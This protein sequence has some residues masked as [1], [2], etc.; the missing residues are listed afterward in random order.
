MHLPANSSQLLIFW[1]ALLR[2]DYVEVYP[3]LQICVR[4]LHWNMNSSTCYFSISS[5]NQSNIWLASATHI[6]DHV[7][8]WGLWIHRGP[9]WV[10]LILHKIQR[11]L[12]LWVMESHCLHTSWV[13][14]QEQVVCNAPAKEQCTTF[15]WSQ[16]ENVGTRIEFCKNN[17]PS[18]ADLF[19][20]VYFV[21]CVNLF[22]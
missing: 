6:E 3:K 2:A 21:N 16:T 15:S 11:W 13:Q 5:I 19:S 7:C 8:F 10:L 18:K 20:C 14:K 4:K 1:F 9:F 22:C 17:K 12:M